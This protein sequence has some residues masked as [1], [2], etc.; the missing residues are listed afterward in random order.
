MESCITVSHRTPASNMSE[1]NCSWGLCPRSASGSPTGSSFL[2]AS[3]TRNASGLPKRKILL[4]LFLSFHTQ[5]C[6]SGHL[7]GFVPPPLFLSC[8]RPSHRIISSPS[9]SFVLL[10]SIQLALS[11]QSQHL[12]LRSFKTVQSLCQACTKIRAIASSHHVQ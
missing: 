11:S 3:R 12:C 5:K 1:D 6:I 7:A 9:C 4:A 8:I 2:S 10:L